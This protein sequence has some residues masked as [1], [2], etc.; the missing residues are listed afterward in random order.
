MNETAQSI[1]DDVNAQKD[2]PGNPHLLVIVL[3]Y[4]ARLAA[5]VA[6]LEKKAGT[7]AKTPVA[8]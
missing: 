5:V 2:T 1:L 3:G 8:S 4:V 6:S 7:K